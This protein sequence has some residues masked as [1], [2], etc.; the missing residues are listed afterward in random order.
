MLGIRMRLLL[1]LTA[2]F[3]MVS[4]ASAS[5]LVGVQAATFKKAEVGQRFLLQVSYEQKTGAQ[6]FR[7][8]RSR[9][10]TF[11]RDG[12]V[13]QMLDVSDTRTSAAHH[14]FA[15]IPIRDEDRDTLSVDLNEGFD[16]VHF[17]EDRT[18][19][20]YYGR[21]DR[22]DKTTFRLFERKAL[23]VSYQD[24]MLVFDQEAR[25]DGRQ[26]VVVHYYL[27]L[28]SP[29]PD[30]RPF[31]MKNLRR[32]GFYEPYPLWRSDRWILYAMKFDVHEPIVFALSSAIPARRRAAVRDGVLYWNR[33]FGRSVIRVI[34]APPGVRAPS[35]AYNVIQWVTS[36]DFTSTSYI[37]SDPLTGQILHAHVFVLPETMMDGDFEQQNDHLRYIV[38]H[39]VGHAIGLR[40]NFAPGAAT[41][42][43]GYFALPQILRMGREIRAGAPALAYD[44]AVVQHVYFGAPLD[45]QT[46]PAFCTD[47]QEGCLPFLPMPKESEGIRGGAS[48]DGRTTPER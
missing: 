24:A 23:S 9:I 15:T 37:Q 21:I 28:Y 22:H 38:A 45:F 34:D 29:S 39:E 27:S 44:R 12:A 3:L 26:R 25:T 47:S 18:G 43:M 19:E 5:R 46:L 10:V 16:R 48:A 42:V 2:G 33:A 32:F 31:E 11:H 6:D 7:T 17:E 30:F 4:L 36:G 20:D 40:H 35:P 1:V 14:P 8:S 13:L 41:T